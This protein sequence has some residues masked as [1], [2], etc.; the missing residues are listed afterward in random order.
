MRKKLDR[1][2]GC[3][4]VS[5][6][7]MVLKPVPNDITTS[8]CFL[9][10]D[11]MISCSHKARLIGL[12]CPPSPPSWKP[13]YGLK[14]LKLL[15]LV[16]LKVEGICAYGGAAVLA[17]ALTNISRHVIYLD[18]LTRRKLTLAIVISHSQLDLV[19]PAHNLFCVNIYS[20]MLQQLYIYHVVLVDYC[21]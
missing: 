15:S 6:W 20:G 14:Y 10:L 5:S 8:S 17:L 21:N 16:S 13:L 9:P 18:S 12:L 7:L 3:W 1:L 2:S 11:Q 19:G 4:T